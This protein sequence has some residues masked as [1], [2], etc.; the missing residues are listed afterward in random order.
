MA[1]VNLLYVK[2]ERDREGRVAYWYFR[3]NHRRW[4]LPGQPLGEDFMAEYQRLR[5]LTDQQAETTAGAPLDK[6]SYGIGTFG[7]LVNDY[8]ES[9]QYKKRKP[10]TKAEYKRILEKLQ[11]EHG[12]K[13]VAHLKRRHI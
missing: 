6:R 3:R 13:T 11:R 1:V 4:R 10:R 8:L 2:P 7:A 9:G 5:A 12:P